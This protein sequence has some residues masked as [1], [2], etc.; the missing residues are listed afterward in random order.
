MNG[1][2]KLI[3]LILLAMSAA[4][5]T[6]CQSEEDKAAEQATEQKKAE[7]DGVE[8]FMKQ[9]DGTVHKRGSRGFATF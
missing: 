9:G 4:L 8:K 5:L 1:S 2:K 3:A 7:Q 6:G